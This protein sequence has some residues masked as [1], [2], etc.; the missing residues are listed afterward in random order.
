MIKVNE[1]YIPPAVHYEY[2]IQMTDL[3][4]SQLIMVIRSGRSI[5]CPNTA[6][7]ANALLEILG[8]KT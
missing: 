6:I 3:E 5:S 8:V 4:R 7:T 1:K 2:T